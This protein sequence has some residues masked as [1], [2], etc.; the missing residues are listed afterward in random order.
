MGE[1]CC[2]LFRPQNI[3]AYGLFL[4]FV[5]SEIV[6]LVLFTLR[7]LTLHICVC[8]HICF[9]TDIILIRYDATFSS[10]QIRVSI[11][12]GQIVVHSI[13]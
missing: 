3:S 6:A 12:H 9:Q 7:L 2:S 8:V 11:E 4:A 5:Y 13:K 1:N 10:L